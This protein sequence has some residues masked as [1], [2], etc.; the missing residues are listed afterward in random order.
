MPRSR[1][2]IVVWD[3]GRAIARRVLEDGVYLV[4]RDPGCTLQLVS[5]R[6]SR[7]HARVVVH[8]DRVVVE[9]LGS[10]NGLY[11]EGRRTRDHVV[12]DGHFLF[13][14]PFV[15]EF[16]VKHVDAVVFTQRPTVTMRRL[17]RIVR[18]TEPLH[19]ASAVELDRDVLSIGRGSDRE[20]HVPDSA[21]SR[22][23]AEIERRGAE[24]VLRDLASA[25]GTWV[26]G[27]RVVETR[28]QDG[29]EVRIGATLFRFDAD[30]T[31]AG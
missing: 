23:H 16:R 12:A 20:V 22:Q 14:D 25:N 8:G 28:L 6:V 1:V 2:D 30:A 10:S 27:R 7:E 26:N 4:G 24:W 5:D 11:F 13:V 21:C 15:L 3:N 18:L 31:F 29:D 9:D 19:G 17:A